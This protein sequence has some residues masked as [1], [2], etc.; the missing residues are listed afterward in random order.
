MH[1][2]IAIRGGR[3]T[4]FPWAEELAEWGGIT[5]DRRTVLYDEGRIY[6]E[7]YFSLIYT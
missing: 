5:L 1:M 6:N 4:D 3:N 7:Q 2:T